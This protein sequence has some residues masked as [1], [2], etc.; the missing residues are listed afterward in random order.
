MFRAIGFPRRILWLQVDPVQFHVERYNGTADSA[1]LC[2]RSRLKA[3]VVNTIRMGTEFNFDFRIVDQ[4]LYQFIQ[5]LRCIFA[6][7]CLVEVVIDIVQR[8]DLIESRFCQARAMVSNV[9]FVI[10]SFSVVGS[11]PR[12]FVV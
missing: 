9:I 5:F 11:T 1:R 2:E 12:P 10:S 8:E 7:I 3:S 6:N 4:Q